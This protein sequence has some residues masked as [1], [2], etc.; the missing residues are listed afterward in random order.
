MMLGSVLAAAGT[1]IFVVA[2]I[3]HGQGSDVVAALVFGVPACALFIVAAVS[4]QSGRFGR[5]TVVSVVAAFLI[6]AV[7]ILAGV[8]ASYAD[9]C[10]EISHCRKSPT[11]AYLALN[12]ATIVYVL[13]GAVGL[14]IGPIAVAGASALDR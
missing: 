9:P 6:V 2:G 1:C 12:A 11:F 14:L 10:F 7:V 13:S 8:S 3:A 4:V 5:A